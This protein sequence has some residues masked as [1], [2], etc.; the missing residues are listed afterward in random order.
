MTALWPDSH[1][2]FTGPASIEQK[3][4]TR[5]RSIAKGRKNQPITVGF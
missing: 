4:I 2:P 1:K 3:L 5:L